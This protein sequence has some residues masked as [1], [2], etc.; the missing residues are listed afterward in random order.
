MRESIS[1]FFLL[2]NFFII[3]K[4][5][6]EGGEHTVLFSEALLHVTGHTELFVT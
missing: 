4:D 2:D 1:H 6:F 3:L 5:T